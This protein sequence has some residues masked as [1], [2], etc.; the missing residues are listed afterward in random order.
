MVCRVQE[1]LLRESL[2]RHRPMLV[3]FEVD[4]RQLHWAVVVGCEKAAPDNLLLLNSNGALYTMRTAE[5]QKRMDLKDHITSWI[6]IVSDRLGRFNSISC[7]WGELPDNTHEIRNQ[8]HSESPC[9]VLPVLMCMHSSRGR[10]QLGSKRYETAKFCFVCCPSL[11]ELGNTPADRSLL[12]CRAT[13]MHTFV[14]II[15]R[16]STLLT[17]CSEPL[18]CC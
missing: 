11:R 8:V 1:Q 12:E 6:P 5:L 15:Q 9:A 17:Q 16:A 4:Q 3:L 7:T 13:A 2:R 14:E 18:S 10:N